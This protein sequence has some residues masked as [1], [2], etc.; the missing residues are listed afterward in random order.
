MVAV[1]LLVGLLVPDVRVQAHTQSVAAHASAHASAS[2][3]APPRCPAVKPGV[4]RA[5]PGKCTTVALTFDDGPGRSTGQILKILARYKVTATF[6][7]L[8][9][10][11]KSRPSLVRKEAKAGYLI[12]DHTWDHADLTGLSAAQQAREL[13]RERSLQKS[14]TGSRPCVFRPPYGDYDATTLRLVAA[15]GMTT[16]TWSVDPEDWKACGSADPYW[17]NRIV[18]RAEAGG[19]QKHPTVLFHNQPN[20]NPAT[21]AALPRVIRYYRAHGYRFVDLEGVER[22]G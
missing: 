22:S 13:D 7:N 5:A 18:S 11:E 21:V 1:V 20:R 15:R 10:N 9:V 8:G 12:G 2:A 19:K 6:F 14:L 17:V 4:H 3:S 16:W